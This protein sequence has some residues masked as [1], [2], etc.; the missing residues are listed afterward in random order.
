[1]I[2]NSTFAATV[3]PPQSL[4]YKSSLATLIAANSSHPHLSPS[5]STG[6]KI[7]PI[8]VISMSN[9]LWDQ[10]TPPSVVL[11]YSET[12]QCITSR[13]R[14]S[15]MKVQKTSDSLKNSF[16][17]YIFR[18]KGLCLVANNIYYNQHCFLELQEKIPLFQILCSHCTY[19]SLER[20]KKKQSKN[21]E[22]DV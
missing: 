8:S 17:N 2:L 20:N 3:A 22:A 12:T 21:H 1:M 14:A 15:L 5:C 18:N 19:E 11:L 9:V 7:F 10:L 16:H 4:S 6:I 13:I